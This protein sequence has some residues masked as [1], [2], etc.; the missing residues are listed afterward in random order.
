MNP[1]PPRV[2]PRLLVFGA[3]GYVGTNLVPALLAAGAGRVRAAA[4]NRKVLEPRSHGTASSW[5]RPMR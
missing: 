5:S 2:N 4:R 3:S 1:G